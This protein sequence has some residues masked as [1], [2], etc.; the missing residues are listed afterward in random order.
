VLKL[1]ARAALIAKHT[2]TLAALFAAPFALMAQPAPFAEA[3]DTATNVP[4]WTAELAERFPACQEQREGV[5]AAAV[6][7]VDSGADVA[8]MSVDRAYALNTD[9]ERANDVW[10]VGACQ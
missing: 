3:A 5:V 10:V 6:V 2:I 1:I 9:T 7:V 4:T 8:R